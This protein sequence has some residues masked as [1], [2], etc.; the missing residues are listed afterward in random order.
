MK[1]TLLFLSLILPLPG[2]C[3]QEKDKCVPSPEAVVERQLAAY[4]ARDIDA[5]IATY[6][7]DI[8][9][10]NSQGILTMQGHAGLRAGYENFFKKT[11]DL[12]CLIENRIVINNKVIDKEK[13]TAG[14]RI[15][16]AVAVYDVTGDKITRVRFID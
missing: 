3:A 1:R 14:E 11:P 7:Q 2:L 9:I 13:V 5:F 6:S 12:H 8:E 4:N 16:H 10:Y 15:I